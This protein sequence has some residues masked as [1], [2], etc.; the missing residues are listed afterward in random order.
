M[1]IGYYCIH[2]SI[3]RKL[4]WASKDYQLDGAVRS[5]HAIGAPS[6]ASTG[7]NH[8]YAYAILTL[9]KHSIS[10]F[11]LQLRLLLLNS[12]GN[13]TQIYASE[14]HVERSI[15]Q[16][17]RKFLSLLNEILFFSSGYQNFSKLKRKFEYK[18]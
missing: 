4:N 5:G 9:L 10:A 17:H 7:Q 3:A 6:V 15:L 1:K 18:N 11:L 12:A 13:I 14:E 16:I 2:W 8:W